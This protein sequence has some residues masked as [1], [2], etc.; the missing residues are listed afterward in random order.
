MAMRKALTFILLP[1]SLLTTSPV[2]AQD[3]EVPYWV[4]LRSDEVNMRVGPSQEYQIDWVYQRKNL[5]MKVVRLKEGWRLVEDPDGEQGWILGRLL[6][7]KRSAIV[8]GDGL[9]DMRDAPADNGELLWKVEPGV[10]GLLGDCEAGWCELNVSG[11]EGWV[12]QARLW[13][14]ADPASGD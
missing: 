3:R 13:G 5:P 8:T 14:A 4:S 11:R 7:L 9:T 12:S 10:V 2:A 1:I 6:S